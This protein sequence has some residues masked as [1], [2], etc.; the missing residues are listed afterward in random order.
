MLS[1]WQYYFKVLPGLGCLSNPDSLKIPLEDDAVSHIG[2]ELL[3][4]EDG[5]GESFA[6]GNTLPEEQV[7]GEGSLEKEKK[8]RRDEY[9]CNSCSSFIQFVTSQYKVEF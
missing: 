7:P 2:D 4:F 6:T 3:P 5:V 1:L 9:D 8:A